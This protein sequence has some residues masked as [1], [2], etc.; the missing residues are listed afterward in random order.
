MVLTYAVIKPISYNN[1]SINDDR[2]K[3]ISYKHNE[4]WIHRKTYDNRMITIITTKFRFFFIQFSVLK[5]KRIIID[6]ILDTCFCLVIFRLK[7]SKIVLLL[8]YY[9]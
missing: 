9:F 1:Y 5:F 8:Y 4:K 2:K 7:P 6:Y 3:K